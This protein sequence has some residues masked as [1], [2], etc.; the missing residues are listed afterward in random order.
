VRKSIKLEDV[1]E[2]M[3]L[4]VEGTSVFLNLNTG[5]VV[6]VSEDD[7][8]IAEE[9]ESVDDL[10]DW[11]QED[12]KTA[13][14]VLENFDDYEKLPTKFEVNEY[15]MMEDFCYE[16]K[17]PR[18]TDTLL[19]AIRGKGAFRRFQDKV[20]YLG[21]ETEWYAF[22]DGRYKQIAVEWC[23]VHNINYAE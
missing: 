17:S 3:E 13:I 4:Q 19:D 22:R 9:E 10:P 12:I 23:N 1:I 8:R 20:R 18:D 21:V 5:E 16:L 2:G 11:Q 7:F 6:S 15:K 14:D